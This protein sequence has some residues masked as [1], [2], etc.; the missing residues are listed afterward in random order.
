MSSFVPR[1]IVVFVNRH[2][3]VQVAD[4]PMQL[5]GKDSNDKFR[6]RLDSFRKVISFCICRA[7]YI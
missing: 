2:L 4:W 7:L 6:A 3:T 5:I 1:I